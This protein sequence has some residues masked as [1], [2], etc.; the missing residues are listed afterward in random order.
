M[1]RFVRFQSP[2]PSPRG[3]HVGVFGL[4]NVLGRGGDLCSADEAHRVRMNR[5]FDAAYTDPSTV[6]RLVYDREVNPRA[7]AWF[8]VPAAD[9]LVEATRG[10]LDILDRHGVAW[11]RVESD[12]PGRVVYEDQHQVVVVPGESGTPGGS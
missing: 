2:E 6:D 8:K 11:E 5:W 1:S 12:D 7:V 4:V 10:H 9:H 3:I